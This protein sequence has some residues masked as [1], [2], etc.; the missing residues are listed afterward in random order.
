METRRGVNGQLTQ[1]YQ[2]GRSGGDKQLHTTTI[3]CTAQA[4]EEVWIIFRFWLGSRFIISD[5]LTLLI[6]AIDTTPY[7]TP[8]EG[9]KFDSDL[10]K[11]HNTTNEY[12]V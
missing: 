5:G 12:I 2:S 1:P 10:M 7:I 9:L 11:D 6:G 3:V 4:K 8:V